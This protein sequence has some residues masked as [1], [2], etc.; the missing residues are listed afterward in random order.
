MQ[1]NPEVGRMKT[2]KVAE[3]VESVR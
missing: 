2:L 3:S 1:I